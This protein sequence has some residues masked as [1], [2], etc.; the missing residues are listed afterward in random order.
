M[1]N[2]DPIVKTILHTIQTSKGAKVVTA[3]K[4]VGKMTLAGELSEIV[5]GE[6]LIG[7]VNGEGELVYHIL[8]DETGT[9]S[10]PSVETKTPGKTDK[11]LLIDEESNVFKTDHQ[12][13]NSLTD[14]VFETLGGTVNGINKL[15]TTSVPY[16]SGSIAV[17][18]NGM[19]ESY[20]TEISSTEIEF[21]E[22]P[23]NIGFNDK[24]EAIFTKKQ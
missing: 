18:V 3:I 12:S 2:I 1:D 11:I 24:I 23:S 5:P 10:L 20:Y 16:K 14:P 13:I 15:F 7:T 21:D 22:P 6:I 8:V 19:K 9:L 4:S 17:F